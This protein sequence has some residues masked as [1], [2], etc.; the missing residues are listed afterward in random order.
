MEYTYKDI[1]FFYQTVSDI[2]AALPPEGYCMHLLCTN[3]S[4][5]VV[6]A[7]RLFQLKKNDVLIYT[8]TSAAEGHRQSSD[9]CGVVFSAPCL[10]WATNFRP[11]ALP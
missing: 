4:A 5:S 2:K 8:K 10:S 9:F 1:R 3:G 11:T 6:Y 7:G